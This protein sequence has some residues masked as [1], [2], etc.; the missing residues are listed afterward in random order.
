MASASLLPS[1]IRIIRAS[2]EISDSIACRA[3]AAEVL[4]SRSLEIASAVSRNT[5]EAS[6]KLGASESRLIGVVESCRFP[7]QLPA[8]SKGV[9]VHFAHI[10]HRTTLVE[11][12]GGLIL[13]RRLRI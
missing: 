1:Q 13:A 7:A 9:W 3:P 10:A 5:V 8:V 12:P 2:S 4:S 11:S 6:I